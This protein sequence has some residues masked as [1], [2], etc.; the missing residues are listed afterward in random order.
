M[1][2]DLDGFLPLE[3]F[4]NED[5][6]RTSRMIRDYPPLVPPDNGGGDGGGG[7]I[8]LSNF[9]QL[10]ARPTPPAAH[11]H[12]RLLITA[13]GPDQGWSTMGGLKMC[14][15]MFG[16]NLLVGGVLTADS[17]AAGDVA[18]L[19]DGDPESIWESA[20]TP[21]DHWVACRFA[22]PVVIG[23][24]EITN[25][26]WQDENV[27][28][29]SIQ[30]SA[31]GITWTTAWSFWD[32]NQ[33]A[34]SRNEAVVRAFSAPWAVIK[35]DMPGISPSQAGQQL[36]V[37]AQGTGLEWVNTFR[38]LMDDTTL[39]FY[40]RP[41]HDQLW[42]RK[43][44]GKVVLSGQDDGLFRVGFRI[45]IEQGATNQIEVIEAADSLPRLDLRSAETFRTRKR[46]SVMTLIKLAPI[47]WIVTGDLQASGPA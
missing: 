2:G 39:L 24:I 32:G 27:T 10:A 46:T 5:I 18:N 38:T 37:N 42:I 6:D 26:W 14:A 29:A 20:N 44:Q 9:I 35:P 15:N 36:V 34:D 13:T 30:Y 11:L 31:D 25:Y 33:A 4:R 40:P 23:H 43:H 47:S 17:T 22:T 21:T 8:D 1:A 28:G 3:Q 7:T 41:E 19:I 12:W 45:Y 16:P